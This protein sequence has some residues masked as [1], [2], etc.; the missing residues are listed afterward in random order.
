MDEHIPAASIADL[1]AEVITR[2]F[3]A[4]AQTRVAALLK[5]GHPVYS[6]GVGPNADRLFMRF[7]DG[8]VARY[9][10]GS[11]GQ[12]IIIDDHVA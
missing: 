9:R 7:P 11:D 3:R 6:G 5:A 1:S 12:R 2:L 10:V 8:R 4:E